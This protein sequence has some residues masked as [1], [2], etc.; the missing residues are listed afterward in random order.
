VLRPI[1]GT[2]GM[3]RIAM[4]MPSEAASTAARRFAALATARVS[5]LKG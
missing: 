2:A 1:R 3:A 5:D 4:A